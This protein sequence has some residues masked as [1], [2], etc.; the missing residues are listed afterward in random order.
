M[1]NE[2]I[3]A[4]TIETLKAEGMFF[5]AGALQFQLG[6]ALSYGC[7]YGMRSTRDANISEF[8]NGYIAAELGARR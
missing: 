2:A 1:S 3:N 8:R 4:R 5:A 7:H 6:H